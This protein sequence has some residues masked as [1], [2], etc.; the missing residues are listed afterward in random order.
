MGT[1]PGS[2]SVRLGLRRPVE[3]EEGE[4]T[5]GAD[6]EERGVAAKLTREEEG[7]MEGENQAADQGLLSL[8]AW[9]RAV[10]SRRMRASS[11]A[12]ESSQRWHCG[13]RY[14]RSKQRKE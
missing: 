3:N 9:L 5:S 6:E 2:Q 12:H 14:R 4:A 13:R 10:L 8:R 7:G 1:F 11:M